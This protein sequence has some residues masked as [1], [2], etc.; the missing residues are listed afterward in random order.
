MDLTDKRLDEIAFVQGGGYGPAIGADE[1]K[2]VCRLLEAKDPR[3]EHYEAKVEA[4]KRLNVGLVAI[5]ANPTVA[6]LCICGHSYGS[7][8]GYGGKSK[9]RCHAAN[10]ACPDYAAMDKNC[11]ADLAAAELE[12]L[13]RANNPLAIVA[14]DA[15]TQARAYREAYGRLKGAIE[16]LLQFDDPKWEPL[17]RAEIYETLRKALARAEAVKEG[18]P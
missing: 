2:E 18:K 13:Q 3:V 1:W 8:W 15:Q 16:Y 6:E 7:H 17:A 10:C 14:Q 12:R 4:A 5:K 9:N 11:G